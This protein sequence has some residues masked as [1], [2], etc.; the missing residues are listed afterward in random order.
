MWKG[1]V[2]LPL[3]LGARWE[4]GYATICA[5]RKWALYTTRKVC[6]SEE[7]VM[8]L[9]IHSLAHPPVPPLSP[10]PDTYPPSCHFL[11]PPGCKLLIY[12]GAF[13]MVTGPLHWE[14]LARGR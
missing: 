1:T 4:W 10:L 9:A 13:N 7:T 14:L 3:Q 12:P 6:F 11:L 5:S 8:C 2:S